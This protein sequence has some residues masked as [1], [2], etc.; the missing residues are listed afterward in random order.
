MG[1]CDILMVMQYIQLKV[2]L[3][4]LSDYEEHQ[5][6][7]EEMQVQQER[8]NAE[9][10]AARRDHHSDG[11][12]RV[13]GDHHAHS[14]PDR[15]GRGYGGHGHSGGR[16]RSG[17]SGNDKE[18]KAKDATRTEAS[19]VETI[20][21]TSHHSKSHERPHHPA[22]HV[23][24]DYVDGHG[25]GHGSSKLSGEQVQKKVDDEVGYREKEQNKKLVETQR[26]SMMKSVPGGTAK[27]RY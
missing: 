17:S 2:I 22:A 7:L 23:H 8:D 16:H 11:G 15:G 26:M 4:R 10:R 25:H 27:D 12:D 21:H 24:K 18:V 19:L 14:H 3:E 13:D 20:A 6:Q 5:L 9:K 1:T